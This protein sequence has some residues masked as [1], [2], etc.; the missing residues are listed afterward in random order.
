M[1]HQFDHRFATYESNGDIRNVTIA[2]HQNPIFVSQPR[3]WVESGEVE[4]KLTTR[5][6]SGDVV[7]EWKQPWLLCFR[8][9]ARSTDER[10]AIFS[11]IPRVA[12]G[13]NLPLALPG[14]GSPEATLLLLAVTSSLVFDFVARQA[15]G[16]THMN[17]YIV[18]Q[19]PAPRP[20]QIPT[21]PAKWVIRQAKDLIATDDKMASIIGQGES[22]AHWSED[23]R[24]QAR[25]ELDAY[26]MHLYGLDEWDVEHIIESFGTLGR[27]ELEIYGEPVTRRLILEALEKRPWLSSS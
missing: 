4:A 27:R 3:Y 25:A 13:N 20:D 12:A 23:R 7:W 26:F 5:D 8:D 9:I 2:E 19:L 22:I 21:G 10:T 15:V 1:I 16:G 24:M 18:K 11:L 6:K 14:D 17:F